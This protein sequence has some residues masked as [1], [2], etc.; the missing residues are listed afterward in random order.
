MKKLVSKFAFQVHNPRRY[1]TAPVLELAFA[2][3]GRRVVSVGEGDTVYIWGVDDAAVEAGLALS[4][5]F[6][7]QNTD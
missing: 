6:C 3:Q 1:T 4:T 7:S 2:S 5:R